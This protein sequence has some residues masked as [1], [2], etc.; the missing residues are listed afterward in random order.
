M[1]AQGSWLVE[2]SLSPKHSLSLVG[3]KQR[4]LQAVRTLQN[5]WTSRCCM[6]SSPH[7]KF[8]PSLPAEGLSLTSYLGNPSQPGH[9]HW[10]EQGPRGPCICSDSILDPS[11]LFSLAHSQ[12]SGGVEDPEEAACA[13]GSWSWTRT[14]RWDPL[15]LP[16]P[17][18]CLSL[19]PPLFFFLNSE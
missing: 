19:S 1:S 13:S 7:P 4:P 2:C 8:L 14:R 15:A 18:F 5:P 6:F 11:Q 17:A 16:C 12:V 3:D 10:E 9:C